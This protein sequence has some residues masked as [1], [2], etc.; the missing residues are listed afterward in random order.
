MG[1]ELF[2]PRG[3]AVGLQSMRLRAVFREH[4]VAP[5]LY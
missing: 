5:E 2:I 3:R 1:A 4:A